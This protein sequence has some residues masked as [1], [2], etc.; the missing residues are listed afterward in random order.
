MAGHGVRLT[1]RLTR[2]DTG[3]PQAGRT[4]VVQ[5][6][7]IGGDRWRTLTTR[8]TDATGTIALTVRPGRSATYRLHAAEVRGTLGAATSPARTVLLRR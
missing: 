5:W 1:G 8:L 7:P 2:L 4:V 6:R 3:E